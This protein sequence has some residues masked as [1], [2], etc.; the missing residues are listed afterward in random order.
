M[1][2]TKY[3]VIEYAETELIF[4]FPACVGHDRMFDSI[5]RTK[6]GAGQNFS[7]PYAFC[8]AISAGFVFKGKCIGRSESLN[9]NSRPADSELLNGM[10]NTESI[11]QQIRDLCADPMWASHVEVAKSRLLS[12][13]ASLSSVPTEKI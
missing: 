12:W 8:N 7:R 1:Y 10:S 5:R 11:A 9:L 2:N 6:A 3:I 4:V 13:A